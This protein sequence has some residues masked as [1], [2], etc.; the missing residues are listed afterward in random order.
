MLISKA[1][2]SDIE[3][4]E[5][6]IKE[7]HRFMADNGI[8]QWQDGYPSSD[9][10]KNDIEKGIA[11]K[12]ECNSKTIAYFVITDG[13]EE[14]YNKI[15]N[16]KWACNG[17]YITVHRLMVSS[18]ARGSGT[19]TKIID[20]VKD[21]AKDKSVDSIRADTHN[22]NFPMKG[23]LLKCGFKECGTI[24]LTRGGIRRAFEFAL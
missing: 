21:I 7:A 13:V 20:F 3:R 16:G 5:I 4:I 9:I 1:K 24:Y 23:L 22:D 18:D 10:I 12:L 15:Y 14:S 2:F 19:A 8:D 6:I 11:Y 17:K